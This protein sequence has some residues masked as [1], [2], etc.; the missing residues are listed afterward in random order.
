[1]LGLTQTQLQD[2]M[3]YWV[4]QEHQV[5]VAKEFNRVFICIDPRLLENL[6][7]K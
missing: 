7:K 5:R 2:E 6:A 1:M 3:K 4:Y